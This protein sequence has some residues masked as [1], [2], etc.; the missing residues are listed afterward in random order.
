M[1]EKNHIKKDIK[2]ILNQK[3]DNKIPSYEFK[4]ADKVSMTIQ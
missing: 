1:I 4:D 3:S 2:D